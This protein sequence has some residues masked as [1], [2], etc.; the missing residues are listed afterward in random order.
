MTLDMTAHQ[1]L[2]KLQFNTKKL[3]LKMYLKVMARCVNRVL[4]QVFR[5]LLRVRETSSFLLK[6]LI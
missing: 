4:S 5:T 6:S 3:R 1:I 2:T